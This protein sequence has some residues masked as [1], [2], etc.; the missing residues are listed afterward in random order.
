MFPLIAC[1]PLS[2]VNKIGSLKDS[3][4]EDDMLEREV[5]LIIPLP[6][7]TDFRQI[8]DSPLAVFS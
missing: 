2:P 5:I 4:V 3:M 1:Q 6:L 7:L 8:S